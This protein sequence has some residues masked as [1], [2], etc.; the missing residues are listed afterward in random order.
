MM[1]RTDRHLRYFLRLIS[2][3]TLLYSEMIPAAAL[4]RGDR[5]ALLAFD[6]AEHPIALQIGGSDPTTLAAS[7]RF[8]QIYGYDEVN[9]NVGCPSPRVAAGR[10]GACLLREPDLVAECMAAMIEAVEIAV[11]V[12]TR[13]GVDDHDSYPALASFVDKVARVGC[14]TFI[15]HARKAWLKGLSPRENRNLPPLRYDVVRRLKADFP[16]LEILVNG[17]VRSLDEAL[18]HSQWAD[19]AMI[20]REAYRNPYLLAQAD[21]RV[22]GDGGPARDRAGVIEAVIPYIERNVSR[23]VPIH[24]IT[25]HL[26]GL[27]HGQPGA[28]RWRRCLSERAMRA[29]A[30]PRVLLGALEVLASQARI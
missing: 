16:K 17:G 14:Q 10:F 4:C 21:A 25:R 29:D 3:R 7:A 30:D 12:K 13:I 18:A 24:Q 27:F 5:H 23:G 26:H 15:V 19:G 9:L 8:A 20:G 28:R 22:F 2:R 11:T 1:A 6:P